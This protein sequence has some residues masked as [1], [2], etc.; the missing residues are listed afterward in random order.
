MCSV[1]VHVRDTNVFSNSARERPMCLC[2]CSVVVHVRD[3][4]AYNTCLVVVHVRDTQA[5]A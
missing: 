3:I 2:L 5:R 4:R 1:V